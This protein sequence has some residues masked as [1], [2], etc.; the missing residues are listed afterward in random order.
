MDKLCNPLGRII[1]LNG[2]SSSGKSTIATELKK[3]LPASFCYYASDQLADADFR[4]SMT[5]ADERLRFFDGFHR[6]I[7]SFALAGNDLIVEHIVE[8]QS[9]ADD[10]RALLAAFDT[11][12]VGV[13][14]DV[15]TLEKREIQRGDRAL[16]EAK[17]HLK[18]H[19]YC[20]YDFEVRGDLDAVT[21]ATSIAQRWA[22]R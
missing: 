5:T 2:T 4:A 3:K 7:A 22:A 11:F 14:C 18:T 21:S 15:E 10:L 16:G 8:E 6:S 1:I 20:T 19:G 9:W 12:W 17:F 13:H